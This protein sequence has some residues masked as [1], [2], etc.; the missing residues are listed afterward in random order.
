M[1]ISL[2]FLLSSSPVNSHYD[3]CTDRQ[4]DR[5]VSSSPVLEVSFPRVHVH[6]LVL[7]PVSVH[8]ACLRCVSLSHFSSSCTF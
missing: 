5:L 4:T 7:A 3:V 1:F 2:S 6:V 8:A